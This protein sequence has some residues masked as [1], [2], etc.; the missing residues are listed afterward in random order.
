MNA[1]RLLLADDASA[2]AQHASSAF[3]FFDGATVLITG[4]TGFVG[5]WLLEALVAATDQLPVQIKAVV[6]TRSASRFM[7]ERPHLAARVTLVEGDV[8]NEL[9]LPVSIDAIIHAAS[10]TNV[11]LTSPPPSRYFD[12]AVRGA[13]SVSS[14]ARRY[15]AKSVLNISSGAAY[16]ASALARGPVSEDVDNAPLTTDLTA[17]YG[18]AKRAAEGMLSTLADGDIRLVISR[19]FAFVGPYLPLRSGYAIGNFIADALS[20][21][22]II[23]CGDGSPIRTYLYA[24]DMAAW[25]WTLLAFGQANRIYNVGSEHQTSIAELANTVSSVLG[26]APVAIMRRPQVGAQAAC[27]VPSTSRIRL[28]LGMRETVGLEEGVRRT[29]RWNV[30]AQT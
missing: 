3:R 12:V 6:L 15:G 26:G 23:V 2:A 20:D 10:E 16:A 13:A 8:R 30:E 9:T 24:A 19:L 14:A 5:S 17:A 7:R 25:L 4:G 21:K 28:E 1:A 22:P 11:D 27:Y 29:A 18:N